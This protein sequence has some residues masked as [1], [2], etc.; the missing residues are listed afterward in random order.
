LYSWSLTTL[1]FSSSSSA[2]AAAAILFREQQH[3]AVYYSIDKIYETTSEDNRNEVVEDFSNAFL[4]VALSSDLV[5]KG[6]SVQ[7]YVILITRSA[8]L[9][10]FF[11][12]TEARTRCPSSASCRLSHTFKLR[13]REKLVPKMIKFLALPRQVD[14]NRIDIFSYAEA[15]AFFIKF[16]LVSSTGE[17]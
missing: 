1:F 14:V 10:A 4:Q 6:V 9:S 3:E 16:G 11:T 5:S 12:Q 2:A 13:A 15:F 8:L 7:P 17:Q